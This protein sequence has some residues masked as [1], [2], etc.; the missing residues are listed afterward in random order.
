MVAERKLIALEDM[1]SGDVLAA[2]LEHHPEGLILRRGGLEVATVVPGR[3]IDRRLATI[4]VYGTNGDPLPCRPMTPEQVGKILDIVG[5]MRNI[6][7]DE[8][9]RVV[10]E[11]RQRSIQMQTEEELAHDGR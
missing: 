6:D 10:D 11:G 8:M 5:S 2:E 9:H 4:P 3:E 1:V 7:T